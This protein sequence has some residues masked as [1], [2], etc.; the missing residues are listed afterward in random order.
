MV[1]LLQR[2]L[3]ILLIIKSVGSKNIS[4]SSLK[5]NIFKKYT[6]TIK[7]FFRGVF[8]LIALQ[9]YFQIMQK[10]L[11]MGKMIINLG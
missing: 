2:N 3:F 9:N 7:F 5:S 10:M 8:L 4:F 11:K 6:I 1:L